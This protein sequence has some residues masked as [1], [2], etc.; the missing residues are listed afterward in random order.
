MITEV[1]EGDVD[2]KQVAI[3]ARE[4]SYANAVGKT[5]KVVAGGY[6]P[7][8]TEGKVIGYKPAKFGWHSDCLVI[9]TPDERLS[10]FRR[11]NRWICPATKHGSLAEAIFTD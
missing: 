4:S 9:E 10:F 2:E 11:G 6:S 8:T 5:A 7:A 1:M 3:R